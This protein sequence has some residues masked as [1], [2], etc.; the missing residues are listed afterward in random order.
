VKNIRLPKDRA[1]GRQ[2]GVPAGA[3]TEGPRWAALAS[4]ACGAW[5]R[6]WGR[7]ACASKAHYFTEGLEAERY[8]ARMSVMVLTEIS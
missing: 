8:L 2:A 3:G 1:G 7:P 4:W 5:S 6:P